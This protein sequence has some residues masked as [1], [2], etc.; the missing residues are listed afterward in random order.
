MRY[1]QL[2][3]LAVAGTLAACSIDPANNWG[4]K[5]MRADQAAREACMSSA[6]ACSLSAAE[7]RQ[8]VQTAAALKRYCQEEAQD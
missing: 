5:R 1:P 7:M 2:W 4:C 8:H 3:L 6:P